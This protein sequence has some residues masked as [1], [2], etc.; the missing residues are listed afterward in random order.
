MGDCYAQWQQQLFERFIDVCLCLATHACSSDAT[1][2]AEAQ[3]VVDAPHPEDSCGEGKFMQGQERWQGRGGGVRAKPHALP[4]DT[5][6]S[7]T[8]KLTTLPSLLHTTTI[9]LSPLNTLATLL[10]KVHTRGTA[11]SEDQGRG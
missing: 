3:G 2:A 4:Q 1:D 7:A 5:S 10:R 6:T 9:T 8:A 11:S